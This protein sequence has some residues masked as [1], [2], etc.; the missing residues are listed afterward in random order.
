MSGMLS[1]DVIRR[2]TVIATDTGL[3]TL[4][5]KL[6][7][8]DNAQDRVAVSGTRMSRATDD[9]QRRISAMAAQAASY[10]TAGF[11]ALAG[12]V[13]A[14]AL[15]VIARF[16]PLV[17]G[18]YAAFK[19]LN[20]AISQGAELLEKYGLAGQRTMFG[21]GVGEAID[22]LTR[23]QNDKGA[24]LQQQKYAAELSGRLDQAKYTIG[25]VLKVQLNLRDAGLGFQEAWV[26]LNEVL[27][28]A[29]LKMQ[30]MAALRGGAVPNADDW[31]LPPGEQS[32]AGTTSS[33]GAVSAEEA[34]R[35]A[36]GRLSAGLGQSVVQRQ[37]DVMDRDDST[38]KSILNANTGNSFT[39]RFQSAILALGRKPDDSA[40]KKEEVTDFE[41]LE[42]SLRR[43]AAAQE[44][45]TVAVGASVG[46]HARLRTEMKL[47]EA[48]LQDIAK[49]GGAM[50]D[51]ED[52]IKKIADRMGEATQKAAELKLQNDIT[53]ERAQIGRD[54]IEAGVAS[55]L[56]PIYG[57]DYVNQM[58][59]ATAAAIRFNEQLRQAKDITTE[60]VTG[61]AGEFRNQ[62]R[63]GV[64]AW[65]AFGQAGISALTRL[66]DKLMDMA[67]TNLVAKAFGGST[68]G[69][70]FSL[71]G[72]GG[73][74]AAA[75]VPTLRSGG[76]VG[77]DGTPQWVHP[78]Y[79]ENAPRMATGG[80]ITDDGVPIIAHPGERV[81]N[82]AETA[83]YNKGMGAGQSVT[84]IQNI[85]ARSPDPGVEARIMQRL[86][87]VVAVATA[88]AVKSVPQA[89]RNNPGYFG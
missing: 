43:Q 4:K 9:A 62:L 1:E 36:R 12:R 71:F 21:E 55:R 14:D 16:G 23:F 45:E 73:A 88:N 69:G 35:I 41:R 83:N 60:F 67:L 11:G 38:A 70:L 74:G 75:S 3:T 76:M 82:R 18:G 54:P 85:D 31:M 37:I 66:S 65:E 61:F 64:G 63:Q 81:L 5:A 33:R 25:E 44:A 17:L 10:G 87:G 32:A 72:A 28:S 48:A 49:N 89:R 15:G 86:P 46:E 53:F 34:M 22:K 2:L 47:Q 20:E 58:N 59:S 78:A 84:I 24:T 29:L 51:Y 13:G 6:D 68:G 79:F 7:A 8:V 42:K 50:E 80:M 52:R 30:Q 19:L 77:I 57:D 56:R 39:A 26:S 40:P 27:A